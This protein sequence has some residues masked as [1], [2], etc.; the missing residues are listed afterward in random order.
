VTEADVGQD[1]KMR[2][3]I[4]NPIWQVTRSR[5]M[6]CFRLSGR[7]LLALSASLLLTQLP[8]K[9]DTIFFSGTGNPGEVS[10]N[11]PAVNVPG[12]S[13]GGVLTFTLT[14][15]AN[16]D[17]IT[18]FGV[19]GSF[20]M[21]LSDGNSTNPW[22]TVSLSANPLGFGGGPGSTAVAPLDYS[23]GC[24]VG[25]GPGCLTL[26][27]ILESTTWTTTIL[28]NDSPVT[29]SIASTFSTTFV[30]A[31]PNYIPPLPSTSLTYD[32]TPNQVSGVPGPPAGA[33]LPGLIFAGCGLLAWRRRWKV[34]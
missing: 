26:P 17:G 20:V 23:G 7:T 28:P 33:G 22:S 11:A 15:G 29:L 5:K 19:A 32:F 16:Y 12:D 1:K 4:A 30:S 9:A 24:V 3:T 13:A 27:N 18:N 21:N 25:I 2:Q 31:D 8:A 34:T 10:L 6:K 14:L